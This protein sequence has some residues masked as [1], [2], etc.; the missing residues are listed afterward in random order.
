MRSAG[1]GSCATAAGTGSRSTRSRSTRSAPS[2]SSR[3]RAG[4]RRPR[5]SSAT[6]RRSSSSALS[7]TPISATPTGRSRSSAAWRRCACGRATVGCVPCSTSVAASRRCPR[8][9]ER[10]S[11]TR[12]ASV[13]WRCSCSRSTAK[14]GR[15]T[16]STRT[17]SWPGASTSSAS[18]PAPSSGGWSVLILQQS[19]ELLADAQATPAASVAPPAPP[20][21]ERLTSFVG[22]DADAT[23]VAALLRQHRLVTLCGPGGVGKTSLAVEVA[24]ALLAESP[25][26]VHVVELAQLRDTDLVTVAIAEALGLHPGED[27]PSRVRDMLL[28]QSALLVLDN[29][30]HLGGAA[31]AAAERLLL[32]CPRCGSSRRAA[33]RSRSQG[34]ALYDVEP[35]PPGAALELLADRVRARPSRP[36]P[37][38][39]ARRGRDDLRAA[40]RT[41][42]GPRARGGARARARPDRDGGPPRRPLRAALQRRPPPPRSASGRSVASSTGATGC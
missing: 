16:P 28:G 41:A 4:C 14:A 3:R 10:C 34:E 31:G 35:L 36:R 5:R 7:P 17:A 29:C 2:D 11:T 13:R 6:S 25:G 37:R 9:S 20:L 27:L 1:T 33:S 24:R 12:C 30:E 40:R 42:T 23:A 18:S 32:A 21:P 8:S 15:P 19:D 38:R 26:G 39:R 22:R